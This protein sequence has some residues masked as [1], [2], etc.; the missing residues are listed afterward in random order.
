MFLAGLVDVEAIF[1]FF[2]YFSYFSL[3][4]LGFDKC[5][6]W[7]VSLSIVFSCMQFAQSW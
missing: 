4:L 2:F 5:Q 1:F 6:L 7:I 3:L